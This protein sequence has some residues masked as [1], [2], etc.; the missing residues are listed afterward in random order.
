MLNLFIFVKST[1]SFVFGRHNIY[2]FY[3]FFILVT[4]YYYYYYYYYF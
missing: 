2:G 3:F 4:N 1:C